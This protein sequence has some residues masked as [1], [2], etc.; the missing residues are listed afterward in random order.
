MIKLVAFD[1]D[2][3]LRDR[4]YLPE[5]TRLALQ[6]LQEQ[7]IILTLCT[8]RSEYEM[9][10]LREELG[11]DW[12]ITCNGTHIGYRG[13][14]VF[15][16]AF[17]KDTVREWLEQADRLNQTL[18]LYG[19]EKMFTNRQDAPYFLQAQQEIGFMNPILLEFNQD[20]PDIYQCIVFCNEQDESLYVG[21]ESNTYYMHRWR[22]W[23]LDINPGG[24]NKAIGLQR[25]LDHL[26]I[27]TNEAA[28][29]GDGL[30]DWEMIEEVGLGIVMGNADDTLK[31]KTSFV[32]RS[33]RED[34][35]AYAV[36]KWIL[37][38]T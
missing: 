27:S 15:G 5:S 4:D 3:T 1:V 36:D 23:A 33:L 34:G 20:V 7:G 9:A 35:I 13:E 21:E 25:L 14:T 30:N 37:Q 26:G 17:A 32:T 38:L 29:F 18:L 19:S 11:I 24:M 28:A 16:S 12:A 2:G 6:R 22:S 10:S 31:Q 8:G